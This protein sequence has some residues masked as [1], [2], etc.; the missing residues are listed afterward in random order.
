[1]KYEPTFFRDSNGNL[2]LTIALKK[3][4]VT[5]VNMLVDFVANDQRLVEQ[6]NHE[7]VCALL[8]F[9]P[10]NLPK[11]IDNSISKIR[12]A[13]PLGIDINE[14][15]TD[16]CSI[17]NID[18]DKL[19]KLYFLSS[20]ICYQILRLLVQESFDINN[21]QKPPIWSHCS[22]LQNDQSSNMKNKYPF[23][24]NLL[25]MNFIIQT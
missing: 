14:D 19:L 12:G 6:L 16:F 18:P 11:L 25:P 9:S 10:S 22:L 4:S 8:E 5:T 15:L 2:P 23:Y 20:P 13:P 24:Y 17:E 1:M 3:Q 21:F 7:E